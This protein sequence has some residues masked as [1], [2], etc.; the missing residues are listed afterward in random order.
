MI[1]YDIIVIG[2]G[3]AGCEAAHISAAMGMKTLLL[4]IQ[5]DQIAALSCNPAIGGIAKSHLVREIDALGGIM[6][7]AADNTGIQ[8][9]M[10]NTGKGPAVQAVRSQADKTYYCIWM[11]SHLEKIPNLEL[12]QAMAESF[13]PLESGGFIVETQQG[14]KFKCKSL[15]LTTGTFL[16]GLIHIG[17]KSFP[18]GRAGEFASLNLSKSLVECGLITDRLKT[19][20]PARLDGRTIDFSVCKPQHGDNP[21]PHFSFTTKQIDRPQVPCYLTHTNQTTHNII[22]DNLDKSALYGGRIHSIGPRYCPS[23]EDKVVK[24]SDKEQHQVFLEPEGMNT[25][26]Y[27]ANGISNSLPEDVQINLVR[28]IKGLENV[29]ITRLAYAIEYTFVQ[30]TELFPSL[31]TKKVPNLFLAG[32][33]NGT[34]GYEEAGAQGLMAGINAVLKIKGES[35]FTLRRDEAY[36]GVMIDDLVTKGT[37]EPY[38]LFSSRAEYRLLL[39]QDN[40]DLRLTDY[41]YK[42]GLI[43]D[44][45]YKEFC[46]Y[47]ENIEK[48]IRRLS[49]TPIKTTEIDQDYLERQ[50]IG[51]VDKS[52]TI[53]QLLARPNAA[54]KDL[55]NIGLSN[56]E[57]NDERSIEQ[58]EIQIKYE[59]Y[60]KKQNEKIISDRKYE[61]TLI[62]DN[63]DYRNIKGLTREAT[64]KLN[65]IRP[66][67]LGQASR[68]PGINPADISVLLIYLKQSAKE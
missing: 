32:Q 44:E 26:E 41:G 52:L 31:E 66:K 51:K 30:P 18:S 54:Y 24:F 37:T 56:S 1:E 68:I 17:D 10:I 64:E 65:K 21:P 11:K 35:P 5:L 29:I 58:I 63:W 46:K 33:I 4:T 9:R 38:R 12:R 25:I 7:I 53:A 34:S 13:I 47:R 16:D 67:T 42:L 45:R 59:G 6:A 49:S 14:S 28:S 40:A 19:G 62:P 8:Y 50:N 57:I 22:K 3:H 61:D 20:T 15:I 43:S 23:I 2:A 60:I 55:I 48:E 27:Y 36:I 39:R